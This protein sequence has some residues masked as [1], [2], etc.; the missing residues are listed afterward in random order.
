[1]VR[2]ILLVIVLLASGCGKSGSNP[3]AGN[4][5]SDYSLTDLSGNPIPM[6][7]LKGKRV[8]L[9]IWATWCRPC[10]EEM[11]SIAAAQDQLKDEN[12]VFIL[13]SDEE[14][15]RIKKFKDHFG[16]NLPFA[17]FKNMDDFFIRAIP[18]TYLFDDTG[19]L[20]YTERGSRDWS[21]QASRDIILMEP[22]D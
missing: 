14:Y 18:V 9:N 7:T 17:H 2:V 11:P 19:Q 10:I 12:V 1:M 22:N 21:T 4:Q 5:L 3:S 13:A 8:F 6:D 20:I 15:E 16:I